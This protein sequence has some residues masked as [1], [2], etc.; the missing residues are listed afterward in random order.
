MEKLTFC[1]AVETE[2]KIDLGSFNGEVKLKIDDL[3]AFLNEAKQKGADYI[4]AYVGM[5]EWS[6][7]KFDS[8]EFEAVY[9][10]NETDEEFE[11][12][13]EQE[14]EEDRKSKARWEARERE[15]FERLKAKYGQ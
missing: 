13:K 2:K 5:D 14:L 15:E 8:V 7:E 6:N 12:R 9:Y 10:K 1:I 4:K 11:K 3:L